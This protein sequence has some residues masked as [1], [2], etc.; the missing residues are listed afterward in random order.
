M[1]QVME[2]LLPTP[3]PDDKG[4]VAW[5]VEVGYRALGSL[6]LNVFERGQSTIEREQI[7]S[8]VT[9]AM[10]LSASVSD[11]ENDAT[12]PEPKKTRENE[13]RRTLQIV[14]CCRDL[15]ATG[16]PIR[17]WDRQSYFLAH[18]QLAAYLAA[19]HLAS[20]GA[21]IVAQVD[22][23]TW[24][25]VLRFYAGLAPA[26]PLI[27]RLLGIPDDLFLNRLWK[28]ADLMAASPPDRARWRLK[29]MKRLAE[30]LMNPG[31]P[32]PLRFRTLEALVE[33][34]EAGV[35]QLFRRMAESPDARLRAAA[36]VG[37]GPVGSDQDISLL[38]AALGDDLLEVRLAAIEALRILARTGNEQ[39]VELI[40]AAVVMAEDEV[41]RIAVQALAELGPEGNAVLR[42][43]A[44]DEDLIVR[45]AAVRGLTSVGEPWARELLESMQREDGEWLVRN[46]AAEALATMQAADDQDMPPFDLSLPRAE[47]ESWLIAWAAERGEGTGV[48]EE[49]LYTL[50]RALIEGDVSVRLAAAETMRQ[51]ADPRTVDDLRKT[52]RDPEPSVRDAA[53]VAL[54]E[55][56]RRHNKRI[57][58]R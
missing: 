13:E 16:A 8:A 30:L 1:T 46:A 53:L 36:I 33:S 48:G 56:T 55:I 5:P 3:E 21:S 24:S 26:E 2:L 25:D 4:H 32:T 6:A 9:E 35:V 34:G 44:R 14:D 23:P 43:A 18:P 28:A 20:D 10:A 37:L 31:L 58:A 57:T 27:E 42:E 45:R 22:D 47:A 7:Q 40:I 17:T 19:R 49:A 54:E 29:L 15:T 38:E 41:Q 51:L 39:A 11:Q 12:E 52:L 50:T